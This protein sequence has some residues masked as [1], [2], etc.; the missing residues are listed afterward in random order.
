MTPF[1]ATS[2]EHPHRSSQSTRSGSAARGSL[3]PGW[4]AHNICHRRFAACFG[5]RVRLQVAWSC[6]HLR[7]LACFRSGRCKL[8]IFSDF[9]AQLN[10]L[11]RLADGGSQ[12]PL[13]L[14]CTRLQRPSQKTP[15]VRR[16]VTFC[17][18]NISCV[19]A[20][21]VQDVAQTI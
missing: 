2:R 15:T 1:L 7:L 6:G 13:I 14:P 17:Q 21:R 12:S 11:F 20:T 19:F 10:G 5:L 4:S 3:V 18:Q 16:S 9:L 8:D